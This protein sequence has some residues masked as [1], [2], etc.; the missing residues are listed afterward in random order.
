MAQLMDESLDEPET[1][2]EK[3]SLDDSM[4]DIVMRFRDHESQEASR[5]QAT[6]FSIGVGVIAIV[7]AIATALSQQT[8]LSMW[9][10][11]TTTSYALLVYV[12]LILAVYA[13]IEW[14]YR[15][16]L[17]VKSKFRGSKSQ[18]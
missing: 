2:L 16:L 1:R 9:V 3:M 6:L 13:S 7:V 4:L 17:K 8:G 11:I 15:S 10:T 5:D 18:R 12:V 14:I